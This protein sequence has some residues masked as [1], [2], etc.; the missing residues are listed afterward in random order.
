MMRPFS[1]AEL[2]EVWERGWAQPP[3]QRAITLL[4]LACPETAVEDLAK[5][6]IGRRNVSLLTLRTQMFGPQLVSL[7]KCSGCGNPLELTFTVADILEAR[8]PE[9][10]E[11]LVVRQDDYDVRFRLP[12]S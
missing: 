2:L 3:L 7:A 8:Q 11:T 12:N 9:A 6:S 5:F 4:A 1:A 10:A